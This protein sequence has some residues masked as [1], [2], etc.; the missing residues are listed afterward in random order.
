[1]D[2]KASFRASAFLIS[3]AETYGYSPYSRRLGHWCSRT[4]LSRRVRLP[5]RR[6][7]F[8]LLENC[9]DTRRLEQLN[10]V[11]GVLVEIGIEN[12]LVHEVFLV[13]DVKEHPSQVMELQRCERVR[14]RGDC[15]LDALPVGA[16]VGFRARLDLR[17]DREAVA[18]GRTRV[19]R[20][21]SAL[22]ESEIA[23]F[24]NRHRSRFGPVLVRR[25]ACHVPPHE[26]GTA[27]RPAPLGR[28]MVTTGEI[29]ASRFVRGANPLSDPSGVRRCDW[30]MC[31]AKRVRSGLRSTVRTT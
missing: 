27:N 9:I 6:E 8:E 30:E 2:A 1:M 22:F 15:V 12:A 3:V 4:N 23:F 29:A 17:D 28:I 31:R 26:F 13:T 21:I 25:S 5:V 16:D 19:R 10:R 18:R 20:P 14:A 24:R 11:L 7:A